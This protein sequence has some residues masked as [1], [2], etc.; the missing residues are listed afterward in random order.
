VNR[1]ENGL[2]KMSESLPIAAMLAPLESGP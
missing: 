2:R 1:N